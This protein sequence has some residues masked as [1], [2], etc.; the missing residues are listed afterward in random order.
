[1][2][3]SPLP[4]RPCAGIMLLNRA[5]QVFVGQRIDTTLEAWQMPQGGID[6]GEDAETAALRELGEET[7]IA[8]DKVALIAAAP[9]ELHYDLPDELIGKVWKGK[10]RGQTQRWFLYRFLGE[11][12]DINIATAHEEFRAWRWIAPADLPRLIVPFKRTLYEQVLA[13]FAD[14]LD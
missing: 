6:P 9:H 10:Y 11:D 13:A 7:G 12:S 5:G 3:D 1:M 4:Y 2:N 14:R 8:P